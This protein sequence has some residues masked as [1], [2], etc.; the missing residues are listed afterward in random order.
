MAYELKAVL[1]LEDKFSGRMRAAAQAVDKFATAARKAAK[2]TG[3]LAYAQKQLANG[4]TIK[5]GVN[6]NKLLNKSFQDTS[7][8]VKQTTSDV[9]GLI[10][11]LTMQQASQVEILKSNNEMRTSFA[12][13]RNHQIAMDKHYANQSKMMH[14][15]IQAMVL[16]HVQDLEKINQKHNNSIEQMDKRKN[17][18]IERNREKSTDAMNVLD[19]KRTTQHSKHVDDMALNEARGTRIFKEETMKKERAEKA[20]ENARDLISMRQ[21]IR[22][23]NEARA[24]EKASRRI[25]ASRAGERFKTRM[26]M[27]SGIP[28]MARGVASSAMTYGGIAAGAG[29]YATGRVALNGINAAMQYEQLLANIRALADESEKA[30][31]RMGGVYDKKFKQISANSLYDP[32][33]VLEAAKVQVKAGSSMPSIMNGELETALNLAQAA[34]WLPQSAA[35]FMVQAK[36]AFQRSIGAEAKHAGKDVNK[37]IADVVTGAANYTT[38]DPVDF[39]QAIQQ[40]GGISG[41]NFEEFVKFAASMNKAGGQTGGSDIGTSIKTFTN[42]ITNP[43]KPAKTIMSQYG[44]MKNGKNQFYGSDGK[45]KSFEQMAAMVY[46]NTKKLNPEQR[47][48]VFFGM[49]GSDAGRALNGLYMAGANKKELDKL[50][51]AMKMGDVEKIAAERKDTAAAKFKMFTNELENVKIDFF[52]S[53]LDTLGETFGTLKDKLIANAPKIAEA[54]KSIITK[55]TTWIDGLFNDPEFKSQKG[56]MDKVFFTINKMMDD[57]TAWMNGSKQGAEFKEKIIKGTEDAIM[58]VLHGIWNTVITAASSVQDRFV[59]NITPGKDGKTDYKSAAFE[60]GLLGAVDIF[61]ANRVYKFLYGETLS[62]SIKNRKTTNTT[63]KVSKG[64]KGGKGGKGGT[65]I[66]EATKTKMPKETKVPTENKFV[67]KLKG[68]SESVADS[69]AFKIGS[70]VFKVLGAAADLYM[71]YD[72]IQE[73]K[74]DFEN[75]KEH[76]D[77]LYDVKNNRKLADK[78]NLDMGFFDW[79]DASKGVPALESLWEN[80]S[81]KDK[82]KGFALGGMGIIGQLYE[83]A[84]QSIKSYQEQSDKQATEFLAGVNA[85]ASSP[86]GITSGDAYMGQLKLAVASRDTRIATAYSSMASNYVNTAPIPNATAPTNKTNP[87]FSGLGVLGLGLGLI[88]HKAG[89]EHRV[90]ADGYRYVHKD[91]AILSRGD[92]RGYRNGTMGGNTVVIQQ[93]AGE[94]NVRNDGDIDALAKALARELILAGG[95][96]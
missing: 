22:L 14:A 84:S 56:I 60:G 67:D 47:N 30:K 23:E 59:E 10:K 34:D 63:E 57:F 74:R 8:S 9:H 86:I 13:M 78:G 20:Y 40:G 17:D 58:T 52:S 91:E 61:L 87:I 6:Q 71:V 65:V 90:G 28:G 5:A 37:Y 55:I 83:K 51:K 79:F 33:Q 43:T 18:A 92:A 85:Q 82:T 50:S 69:K 44:F 25:A 2:E 36:G 64:D 62:D 53:A 7:K 1:S 12:Q 39:A 89:G 16:G 29:V 48:H 93:L 66:D 4:N 77:I 38:L 27:F 72:A 76:G 70:K 80:A 24:E 75:I 54:G 81:T 41:M 73:S 68:F 49:G 21:K 45:M 11:M 88:P 3:T 46:E 96:M 15:M 35:E 31:L 26:G 42:F 95:N 32:Y 19:K 94:L